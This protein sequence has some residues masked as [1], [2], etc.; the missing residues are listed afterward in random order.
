M[1]SHQPLRPDPMPLR[2]ALRGLRHVMRRGGE[3]LAETLPVAALPGP[4]AG[5]AGVLLRGG[6]V[7]A[8]GVDDMA[9]SLAK[10]VLSTG[11][12]HA[13]SLTVIARQQDA[14]AAFASACYAA[15]RAALNR[16]GAG[17]VFVSET[18]ARLAYQQALPR[19]DRDAA[20]NAADL[21][22]AMI[23]QKV[24]RDIGAAE[25]ARVPAD[26][27]EP[28]TVFIVLLWLQSERPED[29]DEAALDSAVD[30]TLVLASDV[31][32]ALS[33]RDSARLAA[34]FAEFASHV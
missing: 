7:L 20:A 17:Q 34:L 21:A 22:L 19:P 25:A 33:A 1:T 18:A 29:E 23:D 16:L 3:T 27:L 32:D 12:A 9:S 14:D 31:V 10:K 30:L 6:E 2:D 26:R 13:P 28:L 15:L 24:L 4:A 5:L 8:R 11:P